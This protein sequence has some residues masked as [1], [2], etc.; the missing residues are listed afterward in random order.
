MNPLKFLNKNTAILKVF[1]FAA[2]AYPALQLLYSY[3]TAQLG[4]NGLETLIHTS[5]FTALI[6]FIITL[7]ITP[8]RRLLSYAMILIRNQYGKRL[9]DWNWMVKLR[10]MLGVFSFLYVLLHF[11]IFFYFEMDFDLSELQIEVQERPYILVGLSALI[12]LFP[13][14][15]TSTDFSMRLLKKYWR[16]L[17]RLMYPVA[18]LIAAHYL[19]LTKPGVYDAYPYVLIIFLLL[20]F[21]LLDYLKII[22]KREDD[23]L[24]AKR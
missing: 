8:L 21:R 5:G 19:W 1:V 6:L 22:F 3:K 15:L 17:H 11:N 7:A 9:G 4:I 24:I 10:R 14:F 12:L 18:V 13:L 2:S 23:G 20:I 16:R